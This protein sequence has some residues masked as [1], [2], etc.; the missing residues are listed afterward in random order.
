MAAAKALVGF[1][2]NPTG[3]TASGS[4][5]FSTSSLLTT[6]HDD[7]F[8]P[9]IDFINKRTGNWGFYYH[10]DNATV[11]NP[12]GGSNFPG[13]ASSTPSRSQQFNLSNTQIIS[14]TTVNEV[15]LNITRFAYRSNEPVTGLGKVSTFGFQESGLGLLPQIPS[16]EGVPIIQLNQLGDSF[17]ASPPAGL[18]QTA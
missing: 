14:P 5:F 12:Y 16:E 11:V 15:R 17:G 1:I 3:A 7:K 6:T 9:R 4:P 18:N 13:F 2:P 8:A 10:Y